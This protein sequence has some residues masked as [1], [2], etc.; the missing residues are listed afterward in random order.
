[1]KSTCFSPN[2]YFPNA[3]TLNCFVAVEAYASFPLL[4]WKTYAAEHV[5]TVRTLEQQ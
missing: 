4:E 1:M 3:L 2:F 5:K